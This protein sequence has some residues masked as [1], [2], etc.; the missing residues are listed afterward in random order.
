MFVPIKQRAR[1]VNPLTLRKSMVVNVVKGVVDIE[2]RGHGTNV[3]F[4][5]RELHLPVRPVEYESSTG[6][7]HAVQLKSVGFPLT[8]A[9]VGTLLE[10]KVGRAC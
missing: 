3:R 9:L 2:V 7:G 5:I 8:H 1:C 10:K 4:K 6:D